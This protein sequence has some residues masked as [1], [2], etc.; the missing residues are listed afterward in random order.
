[1]FSVNVYHTPEELG[2]AA[3][4]R[5]ALEINKAIEKQGFCRIALST[6][7]S[8]FETLKA[9]VEMKV[10]WSK[11]TMFHLDEY[12]GL[13]ETHIASFRKYLKE[14][15]VDVVRP[16]EAFFVDGQGDVRQHIEFLTR[17]ITEKP[18][19][20]GVIGI[21]ENG[22]VAFNDPPADFK[23]KESYIVV[24]LDEKCR[25]Q[26]VHEG[27]FKTVEDVPRQAVSM[28]VSQIMSSKVIVTAAPH[29]VK[30]DAIKQTM[31]KPVT[32]MVPATILKSH[33]AWYLFIDDDSS[34][35]AFP[36]R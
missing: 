33:P 23:T 10:D 29:A 27:W 26:Q 13:S 14:R 2:A 19:D 28:T 7:A 36:V 25:M 3:A 4:A 17:K 5:I 16:K 34:A 30:A 20:V 11:V 15:F 35:K 6:G 1:M 8:Q 31:E 22:H 32:D 24:D 21:G 12:V 18:I 9:L